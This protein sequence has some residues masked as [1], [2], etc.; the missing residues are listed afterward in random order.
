MKKSAK[1]S[2]L[3]NFSSQFEAVKK[4]VSTC[5]MVF[6]L[7]MMGKKLPVRKI[8]VIKNIPGLPLLGLM[9]AWYIYLKFSLHYNIYITGDTIVCSLTFQLT[10]LH[11]W[12]ATTQ[13]WSVGSESNSSV[14]LVTQESR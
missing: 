2:A 12:S 11:D 5:A 1:D 3:P 14:H 9:L 4:N 8:T 10:G 13:L 6:T 7:H